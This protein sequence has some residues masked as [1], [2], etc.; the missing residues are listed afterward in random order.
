MKTLLIEAPS[1][2]LIRLGSLKWA[3]AITLKF[4]FHPYGA[5]FLLRHNPAAGSPA[6]EEVKRPDG[7]RIFA[8]V[9]YEP[10]FMPP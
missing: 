9:D 3:W 4:R 10:A 7:S 8:D 2:Q 5:N 6:W 1:K